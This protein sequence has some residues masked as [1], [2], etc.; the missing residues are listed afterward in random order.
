MQQPCFQRLQLACG[1]DHAHGHAFLRGLAMSMILVIVTIHGTVNGP[2]T[3]STVRNARRHHH[4]PCSHQACMERSVVT[5]VQL[6]GLSRRCSDYTAWLNAQCSCY[7]TLH[8]GH[9][10]AG[11]FDSLQDRPA[12][13]AM[14]MHARTPGRHMQAAHDPSPCRPHAKFF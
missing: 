10:E 7:T 8:H 12:M 6:H 4:P 14:P 11:R 9:K 5:T 3:S 1:A 13:P 2:F